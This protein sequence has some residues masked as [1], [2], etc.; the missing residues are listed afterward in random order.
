M[1]IFPK[2]IIN[3]RQPLLMALG[4]A[5]NLTEPEEYIMTAFI[6]IS[7]HPSNKWSARQLQAALALASEVIDVPFPNVPS[8]A[9]TED[10]KALAEEVVSKVPSSASIALVQGEMTLTFSI[11]R[12]LQKRGINAVAACSERRSVETVNQD[13]TT[14][15][16]AVFEFTQFRSYP[17]D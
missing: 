1:P 8:T 6:N 17:E 3:R 4:M 9:S 7:N 5:Y 15:K 12:Q 11:V 2:L 14:T 10:G 16:T 13:G